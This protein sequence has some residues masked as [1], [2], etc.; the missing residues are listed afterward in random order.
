MNNK[1][2]ESTWNNPMAAIL[3][4]FMIVL[5]GLAF[6]NQTAN[7]TQQLAGS[8]NQSNESLSLTACYATSATATQVNTT[9]SAC[10]K[11]VT[12]WANDWRANDTQCNIANIVVRNGTG[13]TLVA[14]T[15]YR[16]F[17]SLGVIQFLN[18]TS[19][20]G[21]AANLSYTDYTFCNQGY[22]Q[23]SGSRGIA[24]L[25]PTMLVIVL[26]VV[27]AGGAYALFR[28]QQGG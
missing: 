8:M 25:I 13:S 21:S 14:N 24:R 15:D 12:Y 19:T 23:D 28:K 2:G 26:L 22:L 17:G 11:T 20:T 3:L 16:T 4:I 9:A 5:I 7:T 18:T 1:K 27:A 10:N 6:A